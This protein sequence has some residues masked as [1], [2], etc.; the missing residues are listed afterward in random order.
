MQVSTWRVAVDGDR[1]VIT[2]PSGRQ[3]SEMRDVCVVSMSG[4][5][6]RAVQAHYGR[7][8]AQQAETVRLSLALYLC[9]AEIREER[10]KG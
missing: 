10:S 9:D 5:P 4:L 3:Y 7:R 2:T 1:R 8:D 6:A